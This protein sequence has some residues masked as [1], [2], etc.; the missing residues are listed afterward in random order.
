M[1]DDIPQ[2]IE[3]YYKEIDFAIWEAKAYNAYKN[4]GR[5]KTP[6]NK[7]PYII[8]LFS[9][10]IQICE[11][12]LINIAAVL[13]GSN[14]GFLVRLFISNKDL[15]ELIQENFY[16][17]S[18]LDSGIIRTILLDWVFSFQDKN[19]IKNLEN[20]IST[21]SYMIKESIEDYFKY[22]EFLNAYKH[23]YRVQASGKN[24][25]TMQGNTD[26]KA[27]L[28]GEYNSSIIYYSKSGNAIHEHRVSFNYERIYQKVVYVTNTLEC[29]QKTVLARF[30][31]KPYGLN[32]LEVIDK[33]EFHKYFG[34]MYFHNPIFQIQKPT[35]P[36]SK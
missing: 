23:G 36:L 19:L 5:Y 34:S 7:Y 16:K 1:K 17:N 32:H 11:I 29:M 2:W 14:G 25:L 18:S 24:T 10:Y 22:Y 4:I 6:K 8:E 35:T 27:F 3:K 31:G 9:I 13:T 28:V 21:Y 20:K 15:R 33:K 12:L 30:S 26:H